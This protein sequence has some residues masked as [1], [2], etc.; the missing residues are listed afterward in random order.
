[1]GL[2]RVKFQKMFFLRPPSVHP[3][4]LRGVRLG[5]GSSQLMML[6]GGLV[7]GCWINRENH[8]GE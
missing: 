1:M 8:Q 4:P 7:G 5:G 6:D 2:G 3:V